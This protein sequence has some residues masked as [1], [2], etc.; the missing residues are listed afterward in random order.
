ME[1]LSPIN[2]TKAL[3]PDEILTSREVEFLG[4]CRENARMRN[5]YIM[6]HGKTPK[7]LWGKLPILLVLNKMALNKFIDYRDVEFTP[8][9]HHMDENIPQGGLS[10]PSQSDTQ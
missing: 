8:A 6:K 4:A 1:T 2:Q 7:L 9:N 5:E 10:S 3:A